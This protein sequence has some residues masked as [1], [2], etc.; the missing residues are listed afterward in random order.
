MNGLMMLAQ[1]DA[2]GAISTVWQML[3]KGG[4]SMIPLGLVSLASLAI[5]VERFVL[6]RR[7]RVVPAGQLEAVMAARHDT[8]RG[9]AAC[10]AQPSPL[11]AVIAAGLK[12]AGATREQQEKRMGEAAHR[13]IR[14]LR[15]RMRILSAL[16]QAATMLGLLGTVIGMIRTFT[17]IAASADALGKTERLAQG[18][19]EAWTATAAGLVIA[20]PTI[21]A[22]HMLLSRID[23]AAAALDSAANLWLE[24]D[25]VE[26]ARPAAAVVAEPVVVAASSMA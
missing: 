25:G 21:L 22:Y 24:A 19:H 5:V 2:A 15:E 7:S 20:V 11:A 14:K 10:A 9:L 23:A 8:G 16:P 6:T 12:P 18:I 26:A 3:L 13:E 1:D 17:V 4:W